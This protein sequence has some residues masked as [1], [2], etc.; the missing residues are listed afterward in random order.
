MTGN[1]PHLRVT[2]LTPPMDPFWAA[3]HAQL[4]AARTARTAA[5]VL[6]I[7]APDNDPYQLLPGRDKHT[8]APGYFA[9]SG[10]DARL[11]SALTAAGWTYAWSKAPYWWCMRAPDGSGIV[12]V[13]GDLYPEE[14]R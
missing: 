14:A 3:V 2:R 7:F 8:A 12:Y 6:A 1:D 11:S 10:G 5:E 4:H 9:G 13:E